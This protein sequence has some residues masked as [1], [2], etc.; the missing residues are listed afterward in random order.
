MI[1]MMAQV[2]MSEA[3]VARNFRAV[4]EKVR[5]GAEVVVEEDARPVAVIR[6]PEQPGRPIDECIAIS[7]ARGSKAIPDEGFA[8]DLKEIIENHTP[9]DAAPWD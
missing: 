4:L 8:D 1:K 5:L 3:E 2:R 6:M 9:L 7:K